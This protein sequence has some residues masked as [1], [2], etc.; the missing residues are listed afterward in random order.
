MTIGYRANMETTIGKLVSAT[1]DKA[2]GSLLIYQHYL[3]YPFDVNDTQ[4]YCVITRRKAYHDADQTKEVIANQTAYGSTRR[5]WWTNAKRHVCYDEQET[6]Y[7]YTGGVACLALSAVLT[8]LSC[9]CCLYKC[10][11]QCIVQYVEYDSTPA[12]DVEM[13]PLDVGLK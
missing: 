3:L 4:A 11:G 7:Y 6:N 12:K 10:E 1:P 2:A 8:A 13:A 9:G 5:V